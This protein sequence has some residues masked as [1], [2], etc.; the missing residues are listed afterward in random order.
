MTVVASGTKNAPKPIAHTT[1]ELGPAAAAV[2]IQRSPTTA[3]TRNRTTSQNRISLRSPAAIGPRYTPRDGVAGR[4]ARPLRPGGPA[5][6]GVDPAGPLLPRR[7]R[8]RARARDHLQPQLA[9][10]RAGG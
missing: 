3:A 2:A 10:G 7:A 4:P 1:S 9:A 8:P 6:G 5:R